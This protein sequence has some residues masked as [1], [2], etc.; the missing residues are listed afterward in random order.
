MVTTGSA[1]G[2]R[3]MNEMSMITVQITPRDKMLVHYIEY[4]AH[5]ISSSVH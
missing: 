3:H 1:R 2:W 4:I 5:F